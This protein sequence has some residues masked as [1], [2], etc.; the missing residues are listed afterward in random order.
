MSQPG[1]LINTTSAEWRRIWSVR[2]SWI[3]AGVTGCAVV[4]FGAMAAQTDPAS[5][6]PGSTAWDAGQSSGMFA[7]FGILAL[8]AVTATADYGTGGIVPTLQWTPAAWRPVHCQVHRGRCCD[9]LARGHPCG[10][11]QRHRAG[12]SA[13]GP[14]RVRRVVDARGSRV[15]LRVRSF[16]E[17]RLGIP[18]AKHRRC[19]GV[20]DRPCDGPP[21]AAGSTRIRMVDHRV[22]APARFWSVVPHLWRR[23]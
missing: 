13:T 20:G 18:P 11:S 2:S 14:S 6:T 12:L 16:D 19:V 10:C 7:L 8:A 17:R 15:H 4:G 5:V 1:L 9:C 21:D 22:G 3:L 23:A